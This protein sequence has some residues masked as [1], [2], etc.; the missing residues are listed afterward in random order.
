MGITG[1]PAVAPFSCPCWS[2]KVGYNS[3]LLRCSSSNILRNP[4][5]FCLPHIPFIYFFKHVHPHAV[6]FSTNVI[7]KDWSEPWRTPRRS[8][9]HFA[10]V[11]LITLQSTS[12][13]FYSARSCFSSLLMSK[14]DTRFCLMPHSQNIGLHCCFYLQ[15]VLPCYRGK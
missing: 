4:S 15:V 9:H 1:W 10:P 8:S 2:E 5:M 12:Q 13:E 11:L 3:F 6:P 7:P 14:Q